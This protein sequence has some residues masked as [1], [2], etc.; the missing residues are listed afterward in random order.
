MMAMIFGWE[1]ELVGWPFG[2][3]RVTMASSRYAS[4]AGTSGRN[5]CRGTTRM[6]CAT[7]SLTGWPP[8]LTSATMRSRIRASSVPIT[9]RGQRP[10]T[11]SAMRYAPRR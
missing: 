5:R 2:S 6:A 11:S 7:A 10:A 4:S 3:R 9:T 1:D 8:A